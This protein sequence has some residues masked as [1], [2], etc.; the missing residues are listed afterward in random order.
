M[1]WRVPERIELTMMH[2][3]GHK[4]EPGLVRS[5]VRKTSCVVQRPERGEAR[6]LVECGHC[7]RQGEFVIQDMETTKRMRRRPMIYSLI[8]S[9]VMLALVAYLAVAGFGGGNITLQVLTIPAGLL[10]IP[11]GLALAISPSGKLGAV[12]PEG[13]SFDTRTRR[14]GFSYVTQGVRR[15]EGVYCTGLVAPAR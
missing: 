13:V 7:G 2:E 1:S 15:R 12:P 3:M 4:R 11:F 6:F 8:S 9:F 10:F 14:E 5:R